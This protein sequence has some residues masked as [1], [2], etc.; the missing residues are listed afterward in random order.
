MIDPAN[1]TNY[2]LSEKELQY[3]IIFWICAAGKNGT[4]ISRLLDALWETINL[5]NDYPFNVIKND[6]LENLAWTLQVHG[7]GCY[8]LKARA[9]LEIANSDIDLKTCTT[10]DL[11]R[12][13]GIGMK[14]SRCFILHTRPNE[15]YAG[16][17]TH[18]LKFLRTY[19]IDAPISTPSSKKKYLELEKKFI[20]I[21][22]SLEVTPAELDLAIWNQYSIKPKE[23]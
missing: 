23:K 12:I 19:G 11:E 6:S 9:I 21:A 8:K 13:H 2:E 17:D 1:I 5:E 3:N 14:T 7:I 10:E 18:I 16:L 22:D 20:E 4:T 15:R